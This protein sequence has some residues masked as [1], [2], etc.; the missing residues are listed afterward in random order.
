MMGLRSALHRTRIDYPLLTAIAIFEILLLTLPSLIIL[1]VS[2]GGGEIITFPPQDISVKWYVSLLSEAGYVTAFSHSLFV[3][4]FCMVVSIPVGILTA[5]G[6]HRYN[7][8]FEHGLHIYLLLPFTIPLIVS[9]IILLFIYGRLGWMGELWSVGLALTI[10]NLPF[11]IW[12]VSSSVNAFDPELE[13]AARSLGAESLQTFFYITL[14]SLMPGIISGALLM[15]MLGL[16]EFVVSLIITT[17]ANVTLPVEIYSAI[18]GNISPQIAAISSI[19][20]FVAIIGILVANRLVGLDRF[21][22][23]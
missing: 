3:A 17:N 9:G 10:I 20:V 14:P 21:L 19:Y 11:M 22:H 4:T 18:R 13:N 2:F 12:S 23:S 5:I 16:H 7:I 15:F 1:I 6:L 8:R